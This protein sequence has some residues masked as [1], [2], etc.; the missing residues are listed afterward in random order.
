MQL[1]CVCVRS[2]FCWCYRQE[3]NY[4][5]SAFF[6]IIILI[7]IFV[8]RVHCRN[9]C[10]KNYYSL[11]VFYSPKI[12]VACHWHVP[13]LMFINTT[14][15]ATLSCS[16]SSRLAPPVLFPL[17]CIFVR[18]DR[19]PHPGELFWFKCDINLVIGNKM[20]Y[21]LIHLPYVAVLWVAVNAAADG[22]TYVRRER[23]SYGWRRRGPSP[24]RWLEL[25]HRFFCAFCRS[26]T[27]SK[28]EWR[29]SREFAS[30]HNNNIAF[31]V[32]II[33]FSLSFAVQATT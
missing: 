30:R 11:W 22:G 17:F 32:M 4:S 13:S 18:N 20:G 24:R 3:K 14:D 23:G 28:G 7:M 29:F 1:Y 15:S 6:N 10:E 25:I 9:S 33:C 5:C 21:L 8:V 19:V 16:T 12:P 27:L 26:V 31:L 2:R